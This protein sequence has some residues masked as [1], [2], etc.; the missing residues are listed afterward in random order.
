MRVGLFLQKILFQKCQCLFFHLLSLTARIPIGGHLGPG[1]QR[2]PQPPAPLGAELGAW[3]DAQETLIG[4]R[5][6]GRGGNGLDRPSLRLRLPS[7][8]PAPAPALALALGRTTPGIFQLQ[9]LLR[10]HILLG[11]PPPVSSLLGKLKPLSTPKGILRASPAKAR[12]LNPEEAGRE[13]GEESRPWGSGLSGASESPTPYST[14]HKDID[15]DGQQL[16]APC[17]PLAPRLHSGRG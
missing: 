12:G 14:R 13:D 8:L 6:G 17:L 1:H 15:V 10:C 9:A 5:G 11:P 16:E 7:Q 4:G 3:Q 2:Q